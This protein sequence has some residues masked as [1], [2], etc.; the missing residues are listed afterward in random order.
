MA[1]LTLLQTLAAVRVAPL[2]FL[3]SRRLGS[4]AIFLSGRDLALANHG[5]AGWSDLPIDKMVEAHYGI[6]TMPWR[7]WAE[8]VEY[9][10]LDEWDGFDRFLAPAA[11]WSEPATAQQWLANP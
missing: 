9:A 5:I 1:L 3:T 6:A 10:A 4:L 8:I 2:E 11:T 7:T